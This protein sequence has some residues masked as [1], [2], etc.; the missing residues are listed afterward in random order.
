M[1]KPD[2][3][4]DPRILKCAKKEF[5]LYGYEKASTNIIC[6]NAGVTGGALYK[7]YSGKDEL[8]CAIVSPIACQFKKALKADNDSFHS[9]AN[10]NKEA[11]ALATESEARVFIDYIY[12]HFDIFKLLIGCS[13]GSSY[14]NYLDELVD[15][16]VD[17][18]IRFMDETGHEAIICGKVVTPQTIHI[19]VSS[20]LY[21]FFEPIIHD[22]DREEAQIYVE[23][24]KYFFDVGWADILRLKK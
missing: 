19:L 21:G 22:M 4:I 11:A 2:A 1:S 5:L 18:T 10:D 24:L 17:S 14:G 9:L 16:I 8:F 13:K 3:S 12:E 23:Q 6:K 15:I 20:Y 7:R